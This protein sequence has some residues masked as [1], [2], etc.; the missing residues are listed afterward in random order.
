MS[1]DIIPKGYYCYD[2]NGVCPYWSIRKDKPHQRNGYC[3]YLKRGDW[4]FSHTDLPKDHPVQTAMSLIWDQVK[5][6]GVF[7]GVDK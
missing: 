2:E 4:E 6:C 3:S 1:E 5:E 7:E